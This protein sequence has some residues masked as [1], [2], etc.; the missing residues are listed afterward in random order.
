[1]QACG[2]RL[3]F[4]KF[5]QNQTAYTPDSKEMHYPLVF[6]KVSNST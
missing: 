6:R 3:K 5:L 2:K 4:T 1:M